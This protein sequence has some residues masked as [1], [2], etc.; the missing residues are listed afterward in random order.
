MRR[1]FVLTA[2][3]RD[4]PGLVAELARLVYDSDANLDDSRMTILGTDFAVILLCSGARE[5]CG[6][7]LAVARNNRATWSHDPAPP[8]GGGPSAVPGQAPYRGE[9]GG[10]TLQASWRASEISSSTA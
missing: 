1:W 6:D 5:D 10:R 2:I 9:G 7:R 4:R 3:G 8:P